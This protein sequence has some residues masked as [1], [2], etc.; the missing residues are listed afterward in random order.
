MQSKGEMKLVAFEMEPI[1]GDKED[2][3]NNS[4][5]KKMS[6]SIST[7]EKQLN[8][9]YVSFFVYFSYSVLFET[10]ASEETIKYKRK[11]TVWQLNNFRS[12]RMIMSMTHRT[13]EQTLASD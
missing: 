5:K 2:E 9:Q 1:K 11:S 12:N 8:F 3:I 6:L 7:T 10:I 13:F 4:T